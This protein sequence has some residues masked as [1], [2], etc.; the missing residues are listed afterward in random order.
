MTLPY[1]LTF[2]KPENGLIC[3]KHLPQPKGV[4]SIWG[5]LDHFDIH[6]FSGNKTTV[7]DVYIFSVFLH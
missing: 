1:M 3:P 7:T 2:P 4:V 6:T 5:K